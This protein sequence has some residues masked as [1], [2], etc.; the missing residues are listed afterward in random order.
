MIKPEEIK[1]R[2]YNLSTHHFN[3]WAFHE[4]SKLNIGQ[5]ISEAKKGKSTGPCSPEKAAK[6]SAAKKGKKFTDEHKKKLSEAKLGFKH[7]DEWKQ[8]NSERMKQQWSDG[9]RKRKGPKKTMTKDDQA[10]LSSSRLKQLWADPVWAEAQRKKLY[11]NHR[12][13][14]T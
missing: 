11:D 12:S 2:Y 13:R 8:V 10:K 1:K 3:H 9:T 14:K 4:N 7:T 5:K 6:I